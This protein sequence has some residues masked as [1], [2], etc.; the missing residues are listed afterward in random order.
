MYTHALFALV[1]STR[2]VFFQACPYAGSRHTYACGCIFQAVGVWPVVCRVI[3]V[4]ADARRRRLWIFHGG[5]ERER[6]KL[7]Y[8]VDAGGWG[9]EGLMTYLQRG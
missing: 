1:I 3:Y 6:E 9:V 8:V 2:V 4:Y 5:R 7:S